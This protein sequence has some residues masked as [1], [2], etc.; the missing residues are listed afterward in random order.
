MLNE[1][2]SRIEEKIFEQNR[3]NEVECEFREYI[4]NKVDVEIRKT[5]NV[6]NNHNKINVVRIYK[7]C[8][9]VLFYEKS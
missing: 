9:E 1:F 6:D 3:A 2:Q 8:C 7:S 4:K 5:R